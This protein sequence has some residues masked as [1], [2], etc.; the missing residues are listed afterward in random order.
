M[1]LNCRAAFHFTSF[2]FD[3]F[4]LPH[5]SSLS[6]LPVT[7]E[8]GTALQ[9]K[10]RIM[11]EITQ[12][13]VIDIQSVLIPAL[14][15]VVLESPSNDN[16]SVI[17]TAVLFILLPLQSLKLFYYILFFFFFFFFI[18]LSYLILQTHSHTHT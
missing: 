18:I 13:N 5:V 6:V 10:T 11:V 2:C 12:T 16:H 17:L 8:D 3:V 15:H 4:D 7:A 9:R 14:L 1:L